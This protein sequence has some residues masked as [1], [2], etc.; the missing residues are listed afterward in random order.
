MLWS[1]SRNE[2]RCILMQSL[3]K[4]EQLE[5]TTSKKEIADIS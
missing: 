2:A 4:F 1:Q 3:G 5:I